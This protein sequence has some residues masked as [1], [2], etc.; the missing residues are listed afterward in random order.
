MDCKNTKTAEIAINYLQIKT[1][2]IFIL[3]NYIYILQAINRLPSLLCCLAEADNAT[4]HSSITEPISEL[5]EDL[6]K[7]LQMIETTIDLEAVERGEKN[8][9]MYITINSLAICM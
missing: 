7:F 4:V 2:H 5:N 1:I 6:G 9:S 8:T 3:N